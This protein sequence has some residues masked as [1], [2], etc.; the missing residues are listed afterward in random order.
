MTDRN[1]KLIF[2]SSPDRGLDILL[3]MWPEIKAKF[4]DATLD[5]AY[6][7]KVF[8]MVAANNPERMEWKNKIMEQMKQEGITDHGRIGKAELKKVRQQCG[9]WTYPTY[10][11]EINCITALEM[12]REGVVPVTMAFAALKET[13]GSGILVDGDISEPTVKKEYLEK[14]LELMGDEKRWVEEQKKGIEFAS[15]YDWSQ[16]AQDW[17]KQFDPKPQDLKVSIITPTIRRGFWNIMANNIANQTYKNLEWVIVDDFKQNRE[18]IAKEYAKKYKLDIKYYRGKPR[19]IKRTY[20]LVNANNT[21][22]LHCSGQLMVILQDFVLMPETGVEELVILHKQNPNALLA[23][24]DIYR[25]P[26]VK[27]DIESEDWFHGEL[28]VEGELMRKNV[29]VRNEGVRE[30]TNAY[31]FEQ[32]YCA[33]PKVIAQDLGGWYEF[34]DEGLGFDNTEF[35]WRA[36]RA[37][38]KLLV[39]DTNIATCIDHWNALE[40]TEEHGLGREKR[41]NDPR[42]IWEMQMI[43]DGKL[44]LRVTQAINDKIELLYEMPEDIPLGGPEVQWMRD[45]TEEIVTGWLEKYKEGLNV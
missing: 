7:W 30:S 18:E 38:Y 24:V 1:H 44:P 6:G 12:Q 42:F 45:H 29:R 9:I 41:L 3:D 40:G 25:A 28:D 23:P 14:L 11:T 16:I 2:A 21:G 22:L 10:F 35:A 43:E 34:M 26:K 15:T 20:G 13:V 36:L 39:D 32:N 17:I 8:D 31:D 4:P 27:P 5:V 37:G 19:K 33:V